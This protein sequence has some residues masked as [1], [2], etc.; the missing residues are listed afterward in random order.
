MGIPRRILGLLASLFIFMLTAN[1]FAVTCD[2]GYYLPSVGGTCT[3][4][5]E[6]KTCCSVG[7]YLP[8]RSTTCELCPAGQYCDDGAEY[9][10][11]TYP[12]GLDGNIGAGY[13]STGGGTA[14]QPNG[15]GDGCLEGYE[16]GPCIGKNMYSYEGAS[17]CSAVE[18]GYYTGGCRI[19]DGVWQICAFV[20]DCIEGEYCVN[21]ERKFCKDLSD[22]LYP[23]SAHLAW[24]P[25]R[26]YSDDIIG[27]YVANP[28]DST[29]TDCAPGTYMDSHS[30]FYGSTS[31]C[32]DAEPGMY[33]PNSRGVQDDQKECVIGSYSTGGAAACTACDG[34]YTTTAAA[35]DSADKCITCL[36][37]DI[38]TKNDTWEFAATWVPSVWN[39]DNTMSNLCI[40]SAC[41]P[42]YHVDSA[43]NMC[44][45]NPFNIQYDVGTGATGAA[46]TTP[47]TCQYTGQCD[48]PENTGYSKPHATFTGWAC[49]GGNA[50]GDTNAI[51]NGNI[52]QPGD[53]IGIRTTT[54][55]GTI[56]LTAQWE[57]NRG[58]ELDNT[59]V[60]CV[61]SSF[62]VHLNP[63]A[64]DGVT[65][66]TTDI[67]AVYDLELPN[68]P[69]MPQRVGHVLLGYFDAPTGGVQYYNAAGIGIKI[70]DKNT[71][72]TL[73]AQW[74]ECAACAGTNAT[75]AMS[76]VNNVCTYVSECMDGYHT[77]MGGDTAT[78]SCSECAAGSYCT[79]GV[80][81]QCAPGTFSNAASDTCTTCAVGSFS[82]TGAAACTPCPAGT[83]TVATGSRTADTCV[84]CPNVSDN[85]QSWAVQ[86]WNNDN[87]VN[88]LCTIATCQSCAD[89][90]SVNCTMN[91]VNNV[92]TATTRCAGGYYNIQ[93]DTKYNA[94]C[95][96]VGDGYWS[97][98]NSNERTACDTLPGVSL[99]GGK[100]STGTTT[101]EENTACKYVAPE[102]TI[103]GCA[104]VVSQSVTYTGTSWPA[105]I[106]NVTAKGGYI[107]SNNDTA[108]A[109]C[110]VCGAGYFSTGGVATS[111]D[112]CGP[113]TYTATNGNSSCANISA[114]Y[115]S[116]GG[117]TSANGTCLTGNDCGVIDGGYFSTGG[118]TSANGTCLDGKKCGT[119][120]G[121]YFS[122][123][124]GT[125]ANGTC[126]AGQN[127]GQCVAGTFS[128]GGA[129][130]CTPAD[131]GYFVATDGASVQTPCVTGS[132]QD[133]V[134][135]SVCAPCPAGLTTT[136][137]ATTTAASCM[138]CANTSANIQSW[139]EQTWNDDNTMNNL[140][141][142]A[143]C[144]PCADDDSVNCVMNLDNNVC[145]A[146]TTCAGGYYNIQ[147]D[148]KYNASC[149]PVGDGYW[150]ANN[151]NTRT[152][153]ETLT[154]VSAPGGT[155]STG[156]T[157][158]FANTECKY[159]APTKDIDGCETVTSLSITYTGTEWPQTPYFVTATDGYVISG[160]NTP[161]AMCVI[162]GPG[163][164]ST[165][166]DTGACAICGPG[167]YTATDGN[168]SCADIDAGYFSSGGG[169]SATPTASGD[170]CLDGQ[171]CGMCMAGTFSESGAATCTPANIGHFVDNNG[172]NAEVACTTG[173]YQDQTGQTVCMACPDGMTTNGDGQSACNATC[174]AVENRKTW[175]KQTW[176]ADNTVTNLC[177]A[178]SCN[179]GFTLT[180][181]GVCDICPA[182]NYC[183][184]SVIPVN[185]GDDIFPC[186]SV[187][188]P[189]TGLT[190]LWQHSPAGQID[191]TGCYRICQDYDIE[192]G[193]AHTKDDKV[194]Y[195]YV[196]TFWGESVTGNPCDVVDFTYDV[197][198]EPVGGR[199]VETSCKNI[200]EMINGRCEY[201]NRENAM[202]YLPN[203]NCMVASCANG[204]HPNGQKCEDD[205]KECSAPNAISAEYRWN[206][207]T[208]EFSACMITECEAGYHIAANACVSDVQA[209]TTENGR[210]EREWDT[211]T[212][213]WGECVATSCAAGYVL[214]GDKCS[215]CDNAFN[216]DT[217]EIAVSS[218]VRGC[219][220]ATCMYQGEKYNLV[221]NRCELIC[222]EYSDDTGRRY[223]DDNRKRCVN[224]CADG[225]KQW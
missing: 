178:A 179:A 194:T 116:T 80:A 218:Y 210:G 106:Y 71:E 49:S 1:A 202:S 7:Y 24:A 78:P 46:P 224:D 37:S 76:V 112:I 118:G 173:S 138:A 26:C 204:Y 9:S 95:T 129:A 3:L 51:C 165:G 21:G 57:C 81:T 23:N 189:K 123:G 60:N 84:A 11:K 79:G 53:D 167:T 193:V 168:S 77:L 144:Q 158:A 131:M 201:C 47:T 42:G 195:P 219:E 32:F 62:V 126:I 111:C 132:Y 133:A 28:G 101:A 140:C 92:C 2:A 134:G 99:A 169:T 102:K 41:A 174:P 63:N 200:F 172:A 199:C 145:T 104:T 58:Y 103:A 4:C 208:H 98:N 121:G 117:G 40:I 89:E 142:I 163:Y 6:G 90:D 69:V 105:S 83:T 86:T 82:G 13:Y 17:A 36:T 164:Y 124:G 211:R 147:N 109:T 16:C 188:H 75:C 31:T 222:V 44:P 171:T 151:D 186:T 22:G 190:G 91:L 148:T 184:G 152:A 48:A 115:Y 64:T 156:T 52:I 100:Y 185:I 141:T 191:Q 170:G 25:E 217:E 38:D 96:P 196:C 223:W 33:I 74:S 150:S 35:T 50:S 130:T 34:G 205:I 216:D 149:T 14:R 73:Y 187:A 93:N 15:V 107:V 10:R 166:S 139:A 212:E 125:S 198:G 94:S 182:D 67:D 20:E 87:T 153:C 207:T 113:G 68:I 12:Q 30:V 43:Q 225:H 176:N 180:A 159:L 161:N 54:Q 85:I 221:D 220:I 66:G 162:C 157:T 146:T 183:D 206:H 18:E 108:D 177:A 120:N 215:R 137:T 114:G 214:D 128:T 213:T 5:P 27:Q 143:T 45:T 197:N 127:C 119:I 65:A 59:G 72:S 88:N 8:A 181:T 19:V 135:Q 192:Y 209:C 203:G 39:T 97:T 155:Y 160:N 70:W 154:G 56:T 136:D 29:P 55:N 61:S 175:K 110:T 122:N